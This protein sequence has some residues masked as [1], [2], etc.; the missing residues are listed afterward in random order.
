[1]SDT[2]TPGQVAYEAYCHIWPSVDA[3]PYLQ[4]DAIAQ[5]A[6][7]AA[8]QAVLALKEDVGEP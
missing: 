4:L 7:D 1:M 6:W 3:T 5:R 2:R 8:A